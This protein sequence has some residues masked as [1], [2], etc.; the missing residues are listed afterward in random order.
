MRKLLLV[1][2]F[3]IFLSVT[4]AQTSTIVY[5]QNELNTAISNVNA[6][7]TIIVANNSKPYVDFKIN[8]KFNATQKKPVVIKAETVGNVVLTG[9]SQINIGGSY[10]Y[11]EGFSFIG[12]Q[13]PDELIGDGAINFR[14]S[15]SSA[16]WCF[17]CKI[18]NISFNG[19]NQSDN[20]K[21]E[22]FKWVRV[23]GQDNEITNCSFIN[24]YG[25][26]N[27]ITVERPNDIENRHLIHHSYFAN[28]NPVVDSNNKVLNDQDAMRI[29][30]SVTS[31]SASYTKIYN[32]Y[33]YNWKG[34]AE[35][36]S[37]KSSYNEYFN[38]TFRKCVGTLTLRHGTHCKANNNWFF[39]E[40]LAQS[41][42]IRVI[43]SNHQIYNNYFQDLN[44]GGSKVAGAINLYKGDDD[45][46]TGGDLSS[47]AICENNFI[48]FNTIVNCDIGFW[49]GPDVSGREYAPKNLEIVNNLMSNCNK[50]ILASSIPEGT[51]TIKGNIKYLG[52]WWSGI[53]TIEN[54]TTDTELLQKDNE[55]DYYKIFSTSKAVSFA[56]TSSFVID[57]DILGGKRDNK[58]DVG[59][60]EN[61]GNGTN[62][63]YDE[64][65]VNTEIGVIPEQITSVSPVPFSQQKDVIKVFPNPANNYLSII[66]FGGTIKKL[67]IIDISGNLIL[68]KKYFNK[69]RFVKLDL[70]NLHPAVYFLKV[71]SQENKVVI[72]RLIIL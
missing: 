24:K 36:I 68:S 65:D 69:P 2:A 52:S 45:F 72:Q 9:N 50:A 16:D 60:E 13:P 32:N 37:N 22:K 57:Q 58:P 64:G 7:D 46:V 14:Y 63:P 21:T 4:Y 61:D 10:I 35:I 12:T 67:N 11:I 54:L 3:S 41:G 27:C 17:N 33:F 15:T 43:D 66:I 28:R 25:L 29:G 23:Y 55:H 19:Y 49:I 26:G 56:Y 70:S 6:G 59:A 39:G 5:S 42:G 40:N 38:N 31:L 1:I 51:N 62:F 71:I 30:Y 53:D 44:S 20:Y 8:I 48:A 34:E 18:K 47:Y